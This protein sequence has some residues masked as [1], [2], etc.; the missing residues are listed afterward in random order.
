[1]TFCVQEK[2]KSIGIS[3]KLTITMANSFSFPEDDD[4]EPSSFDRFD[5]D[6]RLDIEKFIQ[7]EE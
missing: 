7:L 3:T 6:G 2:P 4:H 5:K 1:V